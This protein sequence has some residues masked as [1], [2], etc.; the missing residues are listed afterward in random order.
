VRLEGIINVESSSDSPI[1]IAGGGLAGSEAAYQISKYGG[2][3][4]LYEMRPHVRTPAHK[5]DNLSELVC[6]NSL[7]SQELTNAHGLLKAEL[8]LLDSLVLQTADET[9]IPGG[10]AL[11]VD[12]V[13]FAKGVSARI[14]EQSHTTVV[15]EEVIDLLPGKDAFIVATGP[16]TSPAFAESLGRLTDSTNLHFFDAISP[17]IDG[18]TVDMDH[19][20][21]GARYGAGSDDYLNCP[22]TREE[23]D[24]FYE[25]L[26][27]ARRVNLEEF[28][29]TPYFEGCLPIEVMAERGRNTLAFG[30]MKPVGLRDPRG[31]P[32]PFAVIQLRRE[33]EAGSMYNLV[34]FQTKL[35]YPEQERVFRLIPALQNVAFFRHGSIHRNTFINSPVVLD[36]LQLRTDGRIFFAGQITGVE[37][38]VESTTIGLLAGIAAL[39]HTRGATFV[40]PGPETCT[41]ALY[42]YIS[43]PRKDF[44]PM[45]VNFGLVEGYHKRHKEQVAEK[46]LTAIKEWSGNI[47]RLLLA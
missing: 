37:G 47:G 8:R 18:S 14:A 23:Y 43:T 38:Y 29:K 10:K 5:T 44:Q 28:E 26:I 40:P 1:F 17:I 34:G 30:P 33:D 22:L 3:A 24:R 27:A 21:F 7:K 42:R 16:L 39:C 6:S 9:S 41:G 12:R 4:V 2:K 13:R 46:A 20:F 15:R 31:G 25:A 11:V 32:D 35:T 45:N 19:A 36:G